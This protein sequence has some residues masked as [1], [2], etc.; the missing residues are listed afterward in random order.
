MHARLTR[1]TFAALPGLYLARQPGTPPVGQQPAWDSAPIGWQGR[2]AGDG[3]RIGHGFQCENAWF[4]PG[5]WHTGEDWYAL[6]GD[7]AGAEVRAIAPGEVVYADFDYPGRVV[8]VQHETDLFS[9][10]G[11][12]DQALRVQAGQQVT[13]GAVL[14]TVLQQAPSRGYRQAPS[15]LHFEMRR[16]L[17]RDDVNGTSPSFGVRCGYQCPP[18]PGYWPQSAPDLPVDLGWL[19]PTHARYTLMVDAVAG[20]FQLQPQATSVGVTFDLRDAPD[21]ERTGSI[22]VE[23]GLLL[24][25]DDLAIGDASTHETGA[26]SYLLWANIVTPEGTGWLQVAVP[27]D[28]ETGTDGRPSSVEF[29]FLLMP[30]HG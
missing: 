30:G 16:F 28:A 27:S 26:G 9:V 7:T 18:G 11:H 8:I 25:V 1:R 5:W 17:V 21:G 20:E 23:P 13:A 22:E 2:V 3:F 4:S 15:H 29:P 24:T 10:Y 12:L 14:G 6:E 19:N